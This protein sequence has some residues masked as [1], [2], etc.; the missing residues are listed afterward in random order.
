MG[1]SKTS[2]N[3][4]NDFR[5][6]APLES[7]VGRPKVLYYKRVSLFPWAAASRGTLPRSFLKDCGNAPKLP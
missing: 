4:L 2:R 5:L 3:L 1:L 6:G 7:L